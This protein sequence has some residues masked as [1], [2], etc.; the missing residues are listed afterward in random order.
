MKCKNCG[1]EVGIEYRLCPYCNSELDYQKPENIVIN[2]Y[3]Y[4]N[5]CEPNNF[6]NNFQKV[7]MQNIS[8]KNKIFSLILCLFFGYFG[9]HQFYVGK[10]GM[11]VLYIFTV[12]LFGFGWFV[13]LI[14]I[15]TGNFKDK[16]GLKLK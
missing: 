8:R 2:N 1:A 6:A 15:A 5:N 9:A 13:D 14:M 12:G 4:S 10:A 3:N 11:G 7:Q 16:Y